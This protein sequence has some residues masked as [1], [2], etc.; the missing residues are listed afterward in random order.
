MYMSISETL[1]FNEL[2]FKSLIVTI[3]GVVI[4]NTNYNMRNKLNDSQIDLLK[5]NEKLKDQALR[6][7]LTKLY[8]NGYLFD[9]LDKA[10]HNKC[11]CGSNFS[12]LMI[13]I[14]NFKS[15]ND[16]YGHLFGDQVIKSVANKLEVLT[17]DI[18]VVCRYG[19]EEFVV[20]LCHADLDIAI[21]IAE[22]IR[23]EVEEEKF[24]NKAGVTVSIG[25]SLYQRQDAISLIKEADDKL[26]MAKNS[27][28][29]KVVY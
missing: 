5:M 24:E 7:S 27:G 18:D 21:Q 15:I 17:R 25:V 19:G 3:I 12:F 26:Y 14:D 2:L 4:S 23:V 6:D 1:I 11:H 28:K 29:N 10:V 8:N 20:I 16:Q 9:F 22:R 13:D